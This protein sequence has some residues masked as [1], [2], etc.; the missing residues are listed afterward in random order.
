[1]GDPKKLKKKYTKPRHPWSKL[2]IEEEGKLMKEYGLGKKKEIYAVSSLLKKY[3]DIAKHLIA[4]TTTQGK[5]EKQLMLDKLQR[6][7]LISAGADVD[8]VLKLE[9][10]D[11]LE[12]RIQSIVFRKGLSRSMKQARQFVI[13]RHVLL[14]NKEITS[15]SYIVT[16]S[17]E[18]SLI[19]KPHSTLSQADHP[20]RIVI[21][22]PIEEKKEVTEKNESKEDKSK[23]IKSKEEKSK[24]ITA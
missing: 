20:E 11:V 22:K 16:T 4:N 17:E 8:Q 14:G 12:R 18:S 9:L 23:E 10:K 2:A 6:I 3:K 24:E 21:A 7:G 13:H 1:M 19:F 5:K 15:P